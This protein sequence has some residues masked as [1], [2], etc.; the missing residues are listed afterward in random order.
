MEDGDEGGD[1]DKIRCMDVML[2]DVVVMFTICRD[3]V[4]QKKDK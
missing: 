1:D 2:K 4:V 3:K